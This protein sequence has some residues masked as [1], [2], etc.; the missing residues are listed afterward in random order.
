MW[1]R[2]A[3]PGNPIEIIER[4]IKGP[5]VLSEDGPHTRDEERLR[6]ARAVGVDDQSLADRRTVE[7]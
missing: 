3:P 1:P 2:R 5:A 4:R 6:V 7:L